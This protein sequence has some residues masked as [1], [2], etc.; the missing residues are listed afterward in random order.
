MIALDRRVRDVALVPQR[1]VLERG[2]QVAAQHTREAASAAPTSPGSA[3]AA[4]HSSPSA[5]PRGT[6]P[7]PRA[8]R[9]AAGGGSRARTTRSSRR[10][11]RTRTCTSAW[12]SRASTCVA[13]HRR[14]ARGARRRTARRTGRRSSTCRPRP[15]ASR[16]RSP[17]RARSRRSRSRRTCIAHSAS[18]TPNVVGSAWMPCV[19]PTIGVSRNSRARAAIAASSVAAAARITVERARH[20][21]RERGVDD[22]ARREAVVDPRAGRR[23][24]ALLHDVDERGDV[25]IGD[26]LAFVDRGDV[27][28][29]RARAPCAP[30]RRG[31]TPSS[32]HAS[33]AST[34]TSSHAP[35]RASSVNRS[36]ISGSGVAGDH[37]KRLGGDVATVVE[38]GPRDP[39][40]GLVRAVARGRD[41][42]P[43]R[44][45]RHAPVR[46]WSR[47]RHRRRAVPGVE[48]EHAVE[49]A[50]AASRPSIT[51]PVR[52]RGRIALGREPRRRRTRRRASRPA[53][54]CCPTADSQQCA[55]RSDSQPRDEHLALGIAEADVVLDDL[56]PVAA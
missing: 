39:G 53:S 42:G 37:V 54:R 38:A 55:Y 33:T 56:R 8:P 12:R 43:G 26:L 49:R 51:S 40:R 52:G 2:L 9:C 1:D 20:L 10:A 16:P 41:V 3:C 6:A 5:H 15:T 11:T 34:S 4:S 25:V 13:G 27:E 31:T 24:D 23:A 21:Q 14:A 46:R 30:R 18:F 19:R 28:R 35:K 32:A 22:V 47:P 50:A 17:S 45:D 7:R 48:D 44:R 29:R 36:A